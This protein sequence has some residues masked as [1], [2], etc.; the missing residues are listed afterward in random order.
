MHTI[1]A[2]SCSLRM[3]DGNQET[4]QREEE[5]A[6][7][8][9]ARHDVTDTHARRIDFFQDWTHS[10]MCSMLISTRQ[11][12]IDSQKLK[13]ERNNICHKKLIGDEK[14]SPWSQELD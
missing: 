8:V 11:E 2:S 12:L 6:Y 1:L 13:W 10:P 7:S 3:H 4:E 14:A 9:V 5:V